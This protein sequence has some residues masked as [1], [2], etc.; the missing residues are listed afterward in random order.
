[1]WCPNFLGPK[2]L[3]AQIYRGPKKV[4]GAKMKSGTTSVTANLLSLNQ[5][6]KQTKSNNDALLTRGFQ[7]ILEFT[8]KSGT[9]QQHVVI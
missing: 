3:R 8:F 4:P 5:L 6:Y 7:G 2:F 9:L 1:M